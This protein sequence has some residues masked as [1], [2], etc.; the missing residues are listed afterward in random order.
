MRDPLGAPAH[1]VAAERARAAAEGWGAW[2]LARQG[3]DD[4]TRSSFNTTLDAL[5]EYG[6]RLQSK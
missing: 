6:E 2:L 4:S 5:L 1:D 3:A